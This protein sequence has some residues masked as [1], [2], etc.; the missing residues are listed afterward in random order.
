MGFF[1]FV[2]FNEKKI[3]CWSYYFGD[4]LLLGNVFFCLGYF[5]VPPLLIHKREDPKY[6][7]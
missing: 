6:L 4:T 3:L 7:R 2:V 5:D 1:I